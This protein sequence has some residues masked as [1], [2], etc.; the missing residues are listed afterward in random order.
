MKIIVG[1]VAIIIA[2]VGVAVA[3]AGRRWRAE[4][5]RWVVRLGDPAAAGPVSFDGFD[6]LPPPVGRYFR[7]VLREGQPAYRLGVL[8]QEGQFLLK[9]PDGWQPFAATHTVTTDPPGFVW[10][11]SIRMGPGLAVRVRDRL[12]DGK[13]SMYGTLFGLLTVV[14]VEGT[15]D[16]TAGSLHRWLAEGPWCPTVLLPRPGLA[17]SPIDD[18]T[19]RVTAT[20]GGTTVSAEMHFGTDG[21]IE[22]VSVA[23]RMRDVNG[24]GVPTP[25]VGRF[26]GYV[27][28]GGMRIPAGGDVGWVID[29]T[30]QPYFRGT[31]TGGRYQ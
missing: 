20:A 6:S 9:A 17:W 15:P 24:V 30:W 26:S 13:G 2:A 18:S 16:I 8:A 27:D 1:L 10:D 19:A 21:L 5:A 14:R 22:R 11:A 3:V 31:I 12:V 29:G 7:A 28:R 23:D 25:W 4:T